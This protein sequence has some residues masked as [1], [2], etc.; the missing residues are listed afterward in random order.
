MVVPVISFHYEV[1]SFVVLSYLMSPFV[2][3]SPVP[4][5]AVITARDHAVVILFFGLVSWY[6]VWF[7]GFSL[8]VLLVV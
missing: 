1:D 8:S 3:V 4:V 5:R 7:L 2:L 6:F